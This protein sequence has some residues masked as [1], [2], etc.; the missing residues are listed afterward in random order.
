M[1]GITI[2][3]V[4]PMF[5]LSPV[6]A[7]SLSSTATVQIGPLVSGISNESNLVVVTPPTPAGADVV[8]STS[9]FVAGAPV[10]PLD[11]TGE[12][13]DVVESETTSTSSASSSETI[14]QQL[15]TAALSLSTIQPARFSVFGSPNQVFSVIMPNTATISDNGSGGTVTV[16]DFL[17]DAGGTP[18][19]GNSGFTTFSVGAGVQVSVGG[20]EQ[21]DVAAEG[22]ETGAETGAAEEAESAENAPGDPFA[23]D[24]DI[25]GFLNVSISYD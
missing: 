4:S 23:F 24:S 3:I 18:M 7:A 13:V 5:L 16:S 8:G 20:A 15:R 9:N 21:G 25:P 10:V 19:V 22:G 11:S 14:Q 6:M 1:I 12:N 2:G 17:H